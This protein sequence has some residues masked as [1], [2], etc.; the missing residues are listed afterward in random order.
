M[1][2]NPPFS[3]FH[4]PSSVFWTFRTPHPAY[5]A[6]GLWGARPSPV[7]VFGVLAEYIFPSPSSPAKAVFEVFI[8]VI[9]VWFPPLSRRSEAK[10]DSALN[11]VH[12]VYDVPLFSGRIQ[13]D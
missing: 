9:C 1:F 11:W 12:S 13:S 5:G 10:T 6:M 7:A 2:L 3:I 4:P 8:P